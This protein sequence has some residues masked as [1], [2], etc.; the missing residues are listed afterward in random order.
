MKEK[1]WG[2]RWKD[3]R[4]VAEQAGVA[5]LMVGVAGS[6]SGLNTVSLPAFQ[7]GTVFIA[8]LLILATVVGVLI[9]V[10]N[11]IRLARSR[12]T[13]GFGA[14]IK[15][16]VITVAIASASVADGISGIGLSAAMVG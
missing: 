15:S 11:G 1:A 16:F 2:A 12:G 10:G 3:P 8:E 9:T 13:E 7:A 14:V 6:V 5:T 4:E